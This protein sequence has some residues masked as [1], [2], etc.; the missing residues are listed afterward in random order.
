MCALLPTV[1]AT[2]M[3]KILLLWIAAEASC[4]TA[5]RSGEIWYDT[6]GAPIDAHG[7]G[8]LLDRGVYY[9][10]GSA[11]NGMNPAC[12]HDHGINLYTSTD[13]YSW[14]HRG[15]LLHT[16]NGSSTGNTTWHTF[17]GSSTR[18][19]YVFGPLERPKVIRC[20]GTGRYVMWVRG[21]GE[22]NDPQLLAVATSDA[23]TGPF[24]FVGDQT[25]PFHT[26]YPGNPNLPAGYQYGD[27]T[28]F[29]DPRTG[30]AYVYWRTRVNPQHTGF[31]G[32]ELTEDCT[33]VRPGSDTQ[34][35][36]TPN[37][38]A[39]AVFFANERFY[40][41]LSGCKGWAP[42]ATY[43][44]TAPTALG[45]FNCSG[46]NN[47]KGWLVGWQP[48][49]IP[50]PGQPGNR[51]R[52]R[53]AA[54]AFGSQSTYVLANPLYREGSA[55]APFVYMADRWTPRNNVSFG[56]YVWLPLF[57][58]PQNASRVRVL[59]RA[60]WRLDNATSPFAAAGGVHARSTGSGPVPRPTS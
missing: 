28:L 37:R 14:T 29:Q 16:F 4:F 26:V 40:L 31:R 43:L 25:D 58:D 35:F 24:R 51:K 60:S 19:P 45:C 56:T 1:G 15:L 6:S 23:P 34:L 41:W 12:C 44:Y 54:W 21:T 42:T 7:G 27:A 20:T 9:W 2:H 49:P 22:L 46:L 38:E 13:L 47:S 30:R 57:I 11:R 53:P 48:P 52:K 59:W 5:F 18:R 50:E 55:L 32:M 10:Y 17:N 36:V 33:D 3:I 8:F 39:P